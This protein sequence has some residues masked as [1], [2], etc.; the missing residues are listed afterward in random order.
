V[1][2]AVSSTFPITQYPLKNSALL[3]SGATIHVFNNIRRFDKY[4]P[5]E[6]GDFVFAGEQ[7]VLIQGY[8]NVDIR[9]QGPQG[10][11][12]IRLYD[13][14]L[15]E[16][17]PCNLVSLHQ[18]H[19][20]GY[21]W[22][23]RPQFNCI[24]TNDGSVVCSLVVRHNQF[25]I[26]DI[27]QGSQE[28]AFFTRR[29]R[30][31]SWTEHHPAKADARKWHLRLGHPGPQALEHLVNTSRG[32]KIR[33]IPT[34][35]CDDCAVSKIRR[36]VHRQPRDVGNG[37]GQRLAI[38]FHDITANPEGKS[39]VMLVTDRWS[40]YIWDCYLSTRRASAII[41]AL[42]DLFSFLLRQYQIKPKVVECDNEIV[43]LNQFQM[44]KG[45]VLKFLRS[46]NI[47]VEFTAAYTPAQNGNAE[48]SGRIIKT[49]ARAMRTSARFPEYLWVEIYR[50]AVYLYNRTPKYIYNWRTPYDRLHTY[51]AH[52]DGIVVEDRKPHQA[53]L[54]VYGCKAFAMTQDALKGNN[55]KQRLNPKA[56]VGFLVGYR[57]T[58]I[59][60]IWNPQTGRV[61]STRDVIFNEDEQFNGD[62]N[63]L[64]DDLLHIGK[65]ELTNLLSQV[66]LPE[67]ARNAVAEEDQTGA[68][69]PQTNWEGLH[70]EDE[71]VGAQLSWGDPALHGVVEDTGAEQSEVEPDQPTGTDEG[72]GTSRGAEAS[73]GLPEGGTED[74]A[75]AGTDDQ[76]KNSD[77]F[78]RP[79]PT[80]VSLP[81][82]ALLTIVNREVSGDPQEECFRL[83]DAHEP[84]EVWK[85][86]FVAGRQA[87]PLGTISGKM[88]DKAKFQRLLKNPRCLHRREMPPLPRSHSELTNHP[89]GTLFEEAEAIHLHSHEEMK[90]WTEIPRYD[91]RARGNQILDCMWV[92]VYKF[93]K[94]GR[95][96]KC[97]ARLV[98]RGDQQVK[99]IHEETYAATLAG[100]SFR[101]LMAIAARFDLELIQYDAVNAFVNARLDKDI[102][103]RMPPGYRKPGTILMLQKALYGLRESPL[104]WQR[105]LTATLQELGFKTVPH[106]PCCMTKGGIIIFFYVDDIVLAY[107]KERESEIQGIMEKLQKRYKL[108]GGKPLQWF[109]G[110]EII[111]DREKRLLWLSQSDYLDKIAN[112]ADRTEYRHDIPL[113]REELLPYNDRASLSSIRRYQRKIGSILY[114]AVITRPDVAFAA[115]RLARF[116][117]NPGPEH[118][119]AA[120][121]VLLYLKNTKSLALQF[122]GDDTFIVASD[123]SFADN[124]IDRK[125][126][127]AYVMRLFGG[128]IGWRANKQGTVTTS[129]T[130]AELLSLA[131]AA[132]EAMF[133]SRLIK[134]LGV[135]LDDERIRIQCDNQQ[136]IQLVN[137]DI[138]K[139]QTKLR[140]VDIHNHWLRQEAQRKRIKVE[141]RPTTDMI[142]DG[143]TKAMSHA[144]FQ[145]FVKQI[146]LTD[147]TERLMD[148]HL[149]NIGEEEILD[150]LAKLEL[151]DMAV[152]ADAASTGGVC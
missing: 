30:Y 130:E 51:L 113:R 119:A 78:A 28:T 142:A 107:K 56:W 13:V 65:D 128:T 83:W 146:G 44:E 102:F 21:W 111:R 10:P 148:R 49:K 25:I 93:D 40:G 69:I 100:R 124:T 20:R 87:T 94:H 86:A 60:R 66:E 22:D 145:K 54:R 117:A 77:A 72:F 70:G 99:N 75:T 9:T 122:G 96:Q 29:H 58:N 88:I 55:K 106:E 19:K 114:A 123:A 27:L 140:H 45:M 34:I 57:S 52:R 33:G 81:P 24:R 84:I 144:Q 79:Y 3:D 120:D 23:N 63:Q 32:V 131:Q 97:K 138:A 134:E 121:Q 16:N 147:I 108:T 95:F 141:Y 150:G 6:L 116:N 118:H 112:L 1:V 152:S 48:V 137:K 46:L 110:I 90:S 98:V 101:T 109:L 126:S 71:D 149:Q 136:T 36:Q 85:A 92:Y 125:S 39:S 41:S 47:I 127:Q 143:L 115:S 37:P 11:R 35:E 2:A 53:H 129:T 135:Q 43:G 42:R 151:H 68:L 15:C 8:G 82:M 132:K 91:T 59:Y 14:A 76:A 104:L 74:Q 67:T 26:D 31:N 5:A 12:V 89:M 38:D 17:F 18:L 62:I 7:R 139:L 80:P 64:K 61:V 133:I 4:R 103:M 50:C 105:D 73:E